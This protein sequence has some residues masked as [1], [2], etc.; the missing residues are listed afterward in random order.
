M[1]RPLQSKPHRRP[2]PILR[3]SPQR[4]PQRLATDRTRSHGLFELHQTSFVGPRIP[5]PT[6][7]PP[8]SH[9]PETA[10]PSHR[11]PHPNRAPLNN[12]NRVPSRLP[13]RTNFHIHLPEQ[14]HPH[15]PFH[16]RPL[17]RSTGSQRPRHPRPHL[18]SLCIGHHAF[19]P[20]HSHSGQHTL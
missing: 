7:A 6:M 11:H 20:E 19:S 10:S 1:V 8:H 16:R 3:L 5:R 2:R 17:H 4:P 9:S 14:N 13:L 15:R 12:H 18:Q